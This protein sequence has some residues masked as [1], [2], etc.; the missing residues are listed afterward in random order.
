MG[1][2]A[3]QVEGL[4]PRDRVPRPS[5]RSPRAGWALAAAL[6]AIPPLV[7]ACSPGEAEQSAAPPI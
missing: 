7:A 4:R 2:S 5:H 1:G 6:V 3:P